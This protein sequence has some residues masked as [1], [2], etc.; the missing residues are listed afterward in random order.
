MNIQ[1]DSWN[2][3]NLYMVSQSLRTCCCTIQQLWLTCLELL[4]GFIRTPPNEWVDIE[5][6]TLRH[7]YLRCLCC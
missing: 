7:S 3:L 1:M 6:R 4:Q 2:P 5:V